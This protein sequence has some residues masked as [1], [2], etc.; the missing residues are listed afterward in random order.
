MTSAISLEFTPG[1]NYVGAMEAAKPTI[2]LQ[3]GTQ[4][5]VHG[6]AGSEHEGTN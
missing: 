5:A 3:P 4:R 1:D 2:F 6:P